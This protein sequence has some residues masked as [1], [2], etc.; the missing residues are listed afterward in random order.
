MEYISYVEIDH[1]KGFKN[2]VRISLKNPA[3]IIGPNNAG[4]TTVI[5]A[6]SLWSMAVREWYA[7][8]GG[9][10]KV[11]ERS[12]VRINRLNV[13]D[14][15]VKETRYYWNDIATHVAS[16]PVPFSITAGL[17]V[18]NEEKPVRMKFT[19]TDQESIYCRPDES[20]AD[21]DDL[22]RRAASLTVNLLYPMSGIAAGVSQ[23]T[24]EYILPE[25]Q[26]RTLMGQG[27]TAAVLRNL[28]Y[29]VFSRNPDDWKKICAV[30][31]STFSVQLNDPSFDAVRSVL[32]LSYSQRGRANELDI[33]LSGR[34]M[35]QILLVLSYLYGHKNCVLMIDE[36][37]AHLELLRQR[38]VFAMLKKVSEETSSQIIMATHSEVILDEA[39]STNLS[40][41]VEGLAIDEVHDSDVRATLRNLGVEHYYNA[42]TSPRL[43]VVEGST[44]VDMLAA[45]AEKSGNVEALEILQGRLFTYYTRDNAPDDS[46]VH[47]VERMAA[48]GDNFKNY[49]FTLKHLVPEMRGLAIFDSDGGQA[50]P[51]MDENGLSI[52]YWARYELENYFI[53]PKVLVRY[54]D[55]QFGDGDLFAGPAKLNFEQAMN[56][57]LLEWVFKGDKALFEGYVK[58]D[59]A[60]KIQLLSSHKMSEF[61]E[62][63]FARNKELSGGRLILEKGEFYKMIDVLEPDEVA[64]DVTRILAEIVSVFRR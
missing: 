59:E 42:R 9:Q 14:V 50:K 8:K 45:F 53:T 19:C 26:M 61:A 34:G 4:K 27:Q 17:V 12:G 57:V 62:R 46:L 22:M 32:T 58:A 36:P 3:V 1:F 5:Q 20:L 49:F 24:E 25:G 33:S 52:R 28:C 48:P 15:P 7:K 39:V 55:R 31:Q 60:V 38:Q 29:Q 10:N 37:D 64:A 30:I 13:F 23:T 51:P 35:Q 6:I 41:L 56:D 44:D 40:F 21:Q 18:G 43:L 47:S 63:V 54:F 2:P 16:G 11:W